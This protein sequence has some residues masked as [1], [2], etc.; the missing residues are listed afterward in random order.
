MFFYS[1]LK[2]S[3]MLSVR[4]YICYSPAG[5]FVLGETVPEAVSLGRY[6]DLGHTFSQY[7]PTFAGE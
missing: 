6:S 2:D 3:I 7:G 1:K 4:T 5:R